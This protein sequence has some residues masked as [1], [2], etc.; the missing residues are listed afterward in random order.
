MRLRWGVGLVG[1]VAAALLGPGAAQ[2]TFQP[3]LYY[4]PPL[5]RVL[6]HV[7][8]NS[9]ELVVIGREGASFTFVNNGFSPFAVDPESEPGCVASTVSTCPIAGIERIVVFLGPMDDSLDINLGASA[10][11]VKQIGKGGPDT[12]E[13]NGTRGKQRLLGGEG[14]DTLRG[15]AGK[16]VLIGGP[17][18]DTCRGGPGRDVI[19]SC[20]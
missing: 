16:D 9:Q 19:E 2:A 6:D 13:L 18:E 4:K 15:G 14:D 7:G 20:E 8:H 12:D 3:E 10:R 11:K 17:G 1:G 5:I